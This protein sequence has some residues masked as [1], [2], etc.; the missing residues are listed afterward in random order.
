[1][2]EQ[3]NLEE[4]VNAFTDSKEQTLASVR[5]ILAFELARIEQGF[6][7]III[8]LGFAEGYYYLKQSYG[9]KTLIRLK[10]RWS[11]PKPIV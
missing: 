10:Y 7:R 4:Y 5:I 11:L 8:T 9:D 1:M 3:R 2:R 6:S